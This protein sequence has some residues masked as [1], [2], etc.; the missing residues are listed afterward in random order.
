MAPEI[1]EQYP[2]YGLECDLWSVGVIMYELLGGCSPFG[3]GETMRI[4]ERTRQADY[5]FYPGNFGG[6]SQEAKECIT[7]LLTIN[8]ETRMSATQALD[9]SDNRWMR[10]ENNVLSVVSIRSEGLK[11]ITSAKANARDAF[12]NEA[13]TNRLMSLQRGVSQ[14]TNTHP[15]RPQSIMTSASAATLNSVLSTKGRPY[16][17]FYEVGDVV[18]VCRQ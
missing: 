13:G 5:V 7:R 4:Y 12:G 17:D 11:S 16:K 18:S 9:E 8:P 6:V 14:F 3:T 10:L 15:T 1:L 2:A